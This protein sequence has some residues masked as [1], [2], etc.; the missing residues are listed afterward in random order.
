MHCERFEWLVLIVAL[1]VIAVIALEE[2]NVS[3]ACAFGQCVRENH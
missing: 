1:L 3:D 2:S